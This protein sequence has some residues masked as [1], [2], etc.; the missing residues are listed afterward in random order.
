M[1]KFWDLFESSTIIQACVTL[2]FTIAI[3][4]LVI[5]GKEVPSEVWAAYGVILGFWFGTKQNYV[6]TK[7]IDEIGANF[8]QGK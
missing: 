5:M 4:V 2:T 6:L 7:T 3:S 8:R 1:R